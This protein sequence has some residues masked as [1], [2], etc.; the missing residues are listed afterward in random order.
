[1]VV[2]LFLLSACTSP[3][4]PEAAKTAYSDF[5]SEMVQW[6]FQRGTGL[7]SVYPTGDS[8]SI[9][10]L[11][12]SKDTAN[13]SPIV[14]LLGGSE[15]GTFKPRTLAKAIIANGY[16]VASIAYHRA[17]GA[18][19]YVKEIPIESVV[20]R[21]KDVS[22]DDKG[23]QRCVAIL[24]V[25]KGAEL[26][27]VIAAYTDF[28]DATIAVVPSSVVWQS[29]QITLARNSSWR[30]HDEPLPFVEYPWF[31]RG[32]FAYLT[33]GPIKA[34]ELHEA[35][36]ENTKILE[37]ASIPVERISKPV[38]LQGA[39]LDSVWQSH[40]MSLVMMERV[41]NKSPNH[42]FTLLAYELDHFLTLHDE[43]VGD[44][45]KFITET[46]DSNPKCKGS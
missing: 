18:P 38:L 37:Q 14:V 34:R 6:S 17:P 39:K 25:S 1:M 4:Q 40:E 10:I 9:Y 27:L 36:I 19:P 12:D 45:I 31:S 29:N 32:M 15:G 20:K 13:N 21:I 5:Y 7:T 42:Q 8:R 33:K 3:S 28:A 22:T 16:S 24:G 41:N 43:P 2:V 44:A 46:F 35:G 11:S 26:A 30:V 23:N